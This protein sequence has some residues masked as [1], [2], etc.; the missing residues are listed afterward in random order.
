[1]V[2]VLV[3]L[4]VL[5]VRVVT[6]AEGLGVPSGD[7]PTLVRILGDSHP[8]NGGSLVET[9]AQFGVLLGPG[10][11][12]CAATIR[13]FAPRTYDGSRKMSMTH[14]IDQAIKRGMPMMIQDVAAPIRNSSPCVMPR[15]TRPR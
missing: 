8:S 14:Q 5:V 2:L 13:A 10:R 15:P 1:M 3:V 4:V 6:P 7:T 11:Q 12:R 9:G